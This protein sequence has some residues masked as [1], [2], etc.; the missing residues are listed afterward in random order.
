MLKSQRVLR[1]DAL[2]RGSLA[3]EP[4][5]LHDADLKDASGM[6]HTGGNVMRH[7]N[8]V[9]RRYPVK[10]NDSR[11]AQEKAEHL[12]SSGASW[13]IRTWLETQSEKGRKLGRI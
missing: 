6:V 1:K 12:T 4:S 7:I 5:I 13:Y 9:T 2:R 8:D 10:A 11:N 3:E